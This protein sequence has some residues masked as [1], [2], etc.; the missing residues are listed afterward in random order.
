MAKDSGR[1][2]SAYELA[3]E[4]MGGVEESPLTDAQK[5]RLAEIKRV[6][7]SKVAETKIVMEQQIVEAMQRG[8]GEAMQKLQE[9]MTSQLAELRSTMERERKKVRRGKRAE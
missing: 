5:D 6:Y 9:E 3:V 4:R 1:I 8:D 2:K 7:E